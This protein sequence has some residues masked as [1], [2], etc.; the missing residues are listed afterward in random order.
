MSE[1]ATIEATIAG[2]WRL[3]AGILAADM[4]RAKQRPIS[5]LIRDVFHMTI[6]AQEGI[7][8]IIADVDFRASGGITHV[9]VKTHPGAVEDWQKELSFL[10]E[11]VSNAYSFD[12]LARPSAGDVIE[13]YYRR[14]AA[15][16]KVTLKQLAEETGYSLAY[17]KTAKRRYD[18][19]G[20]WGSK[21]KSK[22]PDST[23]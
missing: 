23:N 3:L 15:G 5:T 11:A 1:I 6:Y 17:L 22:L 12:E 14:K 21:K 18:A 7:G 16:G 10:A 20:R 4:W 19:A 8:N 9:Q 2:D 13:I